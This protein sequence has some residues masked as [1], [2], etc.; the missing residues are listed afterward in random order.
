MKKKNPKDLKG[1]KQLQNISAFVPPQHLPLVQEEEFLTC[2]EERVNDIQKYIPE[3]EPFEIPP[4]WEEKTEEEI[5]EELLPKEY[6]EK[7]KEKELELAN[8]LKKGA[9]QNKSD[10][11]NNKNKNNN[12]GKKDNK[13]KENNDINN[14]EEEEEQEIIYTPYK[15]PMHEELI[16]NLPISFLRMTENNFLWL[17]PEEYII[18]EK[19]DKDIKRVYPKKN[20]LE[21]RED[22]KDF[23]KL[24]LEKEKERKEKERLERERIEREE[25][26]RKEKEEREK[27]EMKQKG[28]NKDKIVAKDK[29][30]NLKEIKEEKILEKEDSNV[31]SQKSEKEDSMNALLND[32]SFIAKNSLYK[33]FLI[34]CGKQELKIITVKV[35]GF[36]QLQKIKCYLKF[37]FI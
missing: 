25:R 19:L 36:H 7:E 29:D 32:D 5:N 11:K 31:Y 2:P 34:L 28:K 6:I 1:K 21:M 13:E 15:D 35:E 33:D 22:I 27:L 12:I 3:A 20:H 26:E 8:T 16:N 30:K 24:L 17:T 4:E 18:N 10:P 14:N 9:Q 23:H 37:L